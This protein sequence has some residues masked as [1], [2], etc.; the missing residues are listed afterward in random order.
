[1]KPGNCAL[2][3][4]RLDNCCDE[5]TCCPCVVKLAQVRPEPA[6]VSTI[7]G[8]TTYNGKCECGG[9]KAGTTHSVWCPKGG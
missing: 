3:G 9:E 8:V 2:C 1:M 5:A 6:M 7:N 4:M